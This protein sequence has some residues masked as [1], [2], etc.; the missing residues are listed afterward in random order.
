MQRLLFEQSPYF[1]LLC[2][3]TGV[4]YAYILYNGNHTWTKRTN[5]ILFTL[6]A[7]VVSLLAFLLLGPV[8]KLITNEYE[9]PT[10]VFL[11]DSST[12]VGEVIDSVGQVRL[13]SSL[14]ETKITIE[15]AGYEVKWKDLTGNDIT[16]IKANGPTSDLNRGI[17]NIVNEFE[18]RNLAG[19]VVVSDGIYNSGASPLYTPVRVPIY[20]VGLGDTTSRVDLILKNVAFNKV[21]YQGNKFPLKAQVLMQG[22]GNQDVSVTV[23]KD[24]KVLSSEKKNT[25]TKSLIDFDFQLN[26]TEKGIQRYDISVKPLDQESNKRNNAMSIFIEVVDGKK[27]IVLVAPAPHPDIKAIRSVV[28]KNSNYEFIVHI[29]GVANADA[30][31]LKPGEAELVIFHQVIDQAGRTLPVYNSLSKGSSSI[32]LMIGGQSNFRQLSAN[33]I[34]IQFESKGQWDEVAPVVN[35]GFRDFGFSENSNGVFSRYPPVQVPFGKFTYPT[36]ASVLLYQR[37]G[38]VTT[39]RPLLFSLED[40]DKKV[41]ALIGEGLWRW[42]LN[43]FADNGNTEIFDELFSKLIQYLST[44]EDRRKFRSFPLQNEFSDSEPVVIESQVYNDL[45]E[46]VYGNTIQLQ[47]RDEQGKVTNYSYTTSPGGSRYR[48]GGL[49]EGVYRFKATTMLND[50]TEEVSGQFLVRA[51]NIEAQNLTADFELLRKLS[52]ETGGKFYK[53]DQLSLLANDLEKTKAASLIH[54]EETFNQLINLKW[55]FFLLV[56]LITAEWFLRK[57]LGSY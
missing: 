22:I 19:V 5:Q 38:S 25:G 37:I 48:I 3:S 7:V 17:Q 6:R 41:A 47:L 18:G 36:K 9:K 51:Q 43:E 20:S 4:G 56:G 29:P 21:A 44:Q 14:S 50:K 39:D 46:L 40:G 15:N 27:K 24:G 55:V 26:A 35:N 10:W 8:L 34:P 28:E 57:Y 30:S 31:Y 11:I 1:I 16:S 23:L 13:T 54:S 32:L 33:Q 53:Y 49:K 12:S 45:F 42:R 52:S 2:I